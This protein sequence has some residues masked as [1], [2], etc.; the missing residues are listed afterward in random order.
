MSPADLLRTRRGATTARGDGGLTS[1]LVSRHNFDGLMKCEY[2]LAGR[3]FR[4]FIIFGK[5]FNSQSFPTLKAR[6][7]D[8]QG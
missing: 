8:W 6:W 1:R 5:S 2:R 4:T 3:T 7:V